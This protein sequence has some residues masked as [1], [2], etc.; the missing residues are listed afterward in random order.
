M[1]LNHILIVDDDAEIRSLL[2]EFLIRNSFIVSAAASVSEAKKLMSFITFNLIILDV[3]MPSETGLSF[4][5]HL[6]KHEPPVIML[7]AMADVDDRVNGLELGAADYLAKPF[8]PKELLLRMNNL[9]AQQSKALDIS[10]FGE[11]KFDIKNGLLTY[12]D[13]HIHLTTN[14]INLLTFLAQHYGKVISREDII[15]ASNGSI[16]ERTVDAQIARL[17]NK[18]ERDPKNS[19]HLHTVRNKGYMLRN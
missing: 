10:S 15:K 5:P 16:T 1:Q 7:T 8:E 18:I 17:R 4:L 14:E 2:S 9:L 19:I 6:K 11:Y 12:K 3:M 13:K